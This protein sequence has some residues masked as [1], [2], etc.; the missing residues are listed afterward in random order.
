MVAC[1]C[2]VDLGRLVAFD[3][4]TLRSYATATDDD[5]DRVVDLLRVAAIAM[6]VFGH[7]LVAAVFREDGQVE[8]TQAIALLPEA[9]PLTWLFQV[10]PVFFVVGG[11]VN[12]GSWQRAQAAG[13]GWAAWVRRRARRLLVPLVPAVAV[14]SALVV[15]ADVT[16]F[17][18]QLTAEAA[19]AALLPIWFL[20]VY[21]GV[22]ALTP[23]TAW[24]HGRYGWRLL[25]GI[26]ATIA[27]VDVAVRTELTW[28]GGINYLLVW[29]G[30]HQLGYL[31][32]GRRP[33]PRTAVAAGA[34]AWSV[35]LFLVV[36]AGYPGS[37][38]A[39]EGAAVQNTD[40]P[41]LALW[42]YAV[43][44]L[45]W[46]VAAYPLLRRWLADDRCYGAVLVAGASILTVFVWHMSALV[47]VAG[48]LVPTGMWPPADAGVIG[49]VW[50]AWRPV[51][52]LACAAVLVVLGAATRRFEHGRDLPGRASPW[53]T[54]VGVPLAVAGIAWMMAGGLAGGDGQLAVLPLALTVVGAVLLDVLRPA[55]R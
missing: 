36:V 22:T 23:L 41:S 30:L 11:Y 38:V 53:R 12:L 34:G 20:A 16:G 51:W 40:P 37:M 8:A 35:A 13:R 19:R 26:T 28:V 17:D 32:G 42:I 25:L 6:V 5:R 31:W 54:L 4:D 3:A 15:L 47:I 7:W 24:L 1:S 33:S 2:L 44:Q 52:L 10:M 48:T 50:W 14:W 39:V 29:G 9:R 45:A 21:L 43:G 18:P 27:L 49:P 55:P 46:L